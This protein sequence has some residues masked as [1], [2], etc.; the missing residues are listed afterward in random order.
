MS[1]ENQA[2]RHLVD[3]LSKMVYSTMAQ[4]GR[5]CSSTVAVAA[6][7]WATAVLEQL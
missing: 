6:E 5:K 2:I 3:I 4:R 1:L 7:G